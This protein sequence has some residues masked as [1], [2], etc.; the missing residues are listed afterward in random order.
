MRWGLYLAALPAALWAAGGCGRSL[1]TAPVTGRVTYYGK[2][3]KPG[4]VLFI[5]PANHSAVSPLDDDGR[6]AL[7]AAVGDNVVSVESRAPVAVP[8]KPTGAGPFT[9]RPLP[10]IGKSLIP[11]RY[12]TPGSSGLTFSVKSGPNTFDI[13]LKD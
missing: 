11:E 7:R 6:Y 8:G 13:E 9:K 2:A 10:P 5:G 1:E 4:R 12:L 3:V